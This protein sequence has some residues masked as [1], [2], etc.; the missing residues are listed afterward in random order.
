MS[1]CLSPALAFAVTCAASAGMSTCGNDVSVFVA[2]L[3]AVTGFVGAA[4]VPG[5]IEIDL[6]DSAGG[7]ALP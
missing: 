6:A 2:V 3:D 5:W 1:K 4:P 7:G